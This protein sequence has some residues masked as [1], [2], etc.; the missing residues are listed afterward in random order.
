SFHMYGVIGSAIA[1]AMAGLAW[2][3]RRQAKAAS[4]EPI[5][6]P[7]KQLGRGV[8]YVV[9]G[10]LFGLGWGLTGACPGPLIAQVGSGDLVMAVALASALVGTWLYAALRPKLPH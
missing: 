1:V 4:G 2:I 10:T 9:G 5:V 6:I 8:R 7:P 3:R